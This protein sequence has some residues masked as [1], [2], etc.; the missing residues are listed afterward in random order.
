MSEKTLSKTITRKETHLELTSGGGLNSRL[1]MPAGV[2]L[3]DNNFWM[4]QDKNAKV[5]YGDDSV[6]ID[7][8]PFSL[9]H[10]QVQIFD[11][12]KHLYI[13]KDSFTPGRDGIIAFG[14]RMKA[15]ITKNHADDYRDGFCAFNVL[16]FTTGMVFDIISNGGK[17]WVI[18]ERLLMPGVT[19]EKEAFTHVIPIKK[20][21][22]DDDTLDCLTVYDSARNT[23]EYYIDRELVH[24][25][26]NIPVKA[27][28][29]QTAFG[30][31][32]LH[33]IKNGKSISC[34]GQGGVGTWSDF[35][36]YRD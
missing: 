35:R 20:A 3:G 22:S 13:S 23:V 28:S 19:T 32:T 17:L 30:L 34:R 14:C 24:T 4:Y 11:N 21:V 15:A 16:D 1:W 7:I 9:A 8:S 31:I 25:A 5:G 33:P 26:E 10:D 29:L 6:T 18:Y 36:L 27:E 2:P 12:P